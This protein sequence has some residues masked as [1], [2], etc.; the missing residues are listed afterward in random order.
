M[1]TPY[2][3]SAITGVVVAVIAALTPIDIVAELVNIGTLLAFVLVSLGVVILR[4]TNPQM[5]RAFRTPCVPLV[6]VLA[7]LICFYLMVSL[8][9]VTW[10]RFF[11]WLIA[12]TVIYFLYGR[13]HSRLALEEMASE[14]IKGIGKTLILEDKQ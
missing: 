7:V 6:P 13:H 9:L 2:R 14:E 10:V 12:G 3:I 8:P 4:R 5:P 11:S 1:G